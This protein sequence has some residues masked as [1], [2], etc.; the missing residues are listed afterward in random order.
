MAKLPEYVSP[1][2]VR[3]ASSLFNQVMQCSVTG[4]SVRRQSCLKDKII[5]TTHSENPSIT[6][7]QVQNETATKH[8]SGESSPSS[9]VP[10]SS[11]ELLISYCASQRVAQG[12]VLARAFQN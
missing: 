4:N 8:F 11:V 5:G 2:T 6:S 1:K 9:A 12:P 3:A 7:L 10:R